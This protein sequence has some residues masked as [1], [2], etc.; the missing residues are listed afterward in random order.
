MSKGEQF[1]MDGLPHMMKAVYGLLACTALASMMTVGSF[2][3]T[4]DGNQVSREMDAEI[5]NSLKETASIVSEVSANQ[6]MIIYRLEIQE[7]KE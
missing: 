5:R 7:G 2:V 4:R 1:L 6:K 3:Y